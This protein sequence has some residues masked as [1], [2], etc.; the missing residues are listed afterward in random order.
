MLFQRL[1]F[2][3]WGIAFALATPDGPF[4]EINAVLSRAQIG[5]Q[6]KQEFSAAGATITVSGIM[7]KG[8]SLGDLLVETQG[9]P[10]G[11]ND[12]DRR[13]RYHT[14]LQRKLGS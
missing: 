5:V 4:A 6:N 7:C 2:L 8:I 14:R 13:Q 9:K 1:V 12:D 11:E 10:D 3:L